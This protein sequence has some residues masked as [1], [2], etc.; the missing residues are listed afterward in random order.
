MLQRQE[1]RLYVADLDDRLE[2]HVGLTRA[3]DFLAVLTSGTDSTFVQ[4][5]REGDRSA[6]FLR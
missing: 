3:E 2:L 4:E 1:R 5:L 6:Q